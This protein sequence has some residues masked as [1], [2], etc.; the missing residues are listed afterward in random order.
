MTDHI[1][2]QT[3]RLYVRTWRECDLPA[4]HQVLSDPLVQ[5]FTAEKPF[6]QEDSRA[7]IVWARQHRL[8][9]EPSYF[10]CPL[11][12]RETD[13]V[14]GRVG[15]NPFMKTS[16]IPE[17]EWT[18]GPAYWRMGYAA[19]IGRAMFAYAFEEAGFSA[20]MGFALPNHL[21]SR[22][23]MEKLGMSYLGDK[24]HNGQ[25]YSFYRMANPLKEDG[26]PSSGLPLSG[27][28]SAPRPVAWSSERL[29][30]FERIGRSGKPKDVDYL[31][32]VLETT[33]DLG[34]IKLVDY[35]LGLVSGRAG[36]DQIK[37]YLYQGT[38]RQRNYA[39][40]YFKRRNSTRILKKAVDAGLI[41]VTQAF[42]K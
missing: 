18:L 1:F 40:L 37:T 23:L 7:L 26:Y 30:D 14:I 27:A 22:R 41:D 28:R 16:R 31:M 32:S 38:L 29:S 36:R 9:W 19:E 2:I 6:T 10:N 35:A 34:A 4:I 8:G 13:Q 17:I 33:D 15:L 24:G 25:V 42:S 5:R 20:I 39:A 21:A 11:I 3:Q 12:L